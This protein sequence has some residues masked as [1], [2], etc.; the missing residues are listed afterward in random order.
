MCFV[1]YLALEVKKIFIIRGNKINEIHSTK[2]TH[3]YIIYNIKYFI[4]I[5][6]IFNNI[7]FIIKGCVKL[8]TGEET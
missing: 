3:S 6:K 8:L 2:S 4:K 5:N 1:Q 7:F